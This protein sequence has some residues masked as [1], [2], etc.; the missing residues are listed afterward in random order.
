MEELRG[1]GLAPFTSMRLGGPAARLIVAT[2][3]D[4]IVEAVSDLDAQGERFYVIGGGSNVVV[5]DS[6]FSGTAVLIRSR[7]IGVSGSRIVAEAGEPWEKLVEAATAASLAGLECLAGIPGTAGAAPVQ[8]VGG[9]GQAVGD[10][11]ASVEVYDRAQ[12]RRRT[13]HKRADQDQLRLGY[14]TSR[15]KEGRDR[16][17]FVILRVEFV[18]RP[19]PVSIGLTY[20]DL[21]HNLGVSDDTEVPLADVNAAVMEVRG[22]K[23]M[24][25]SPSDPESVS[26]GS[27]F[28]NPTITPQ[29]H[30]GLV[31]S[32]AATRGPDERVPRRGIDR[33]TGELT[34]FA[35][36]LVEQAGFVKGYQR[37][38]SSVAI[39]RKHSLALVNREPANP[40]PDAFADLVALAS[41]IWQTVFYRFGVALG[42]EPDVVGSSWS[43]HL[44]PDYR[45]ERPSTNPGCP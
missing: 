34:V 2:T 13:L 28:T 18:L 26:T 36:S 7:G 27:F 16:D 38:G 12:R 11:I 32:V 14:R 23:G 41:E 8:N 6:G 15:F 39:S 21:I 37:P 44:G 24:V 42:V 43:A 10:T 20:G 9:Y 5:P 35:A 22:K 17:R 45:E 29:Q 3:A 4:E 19:S 31:A 33:Q 25:I 1:V 30:A 40:R